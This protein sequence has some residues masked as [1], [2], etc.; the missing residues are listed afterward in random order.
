MALPDPREHPD[1]LARETRTLL[2]RY[3]LVPRRSL[4]QS[5]LTSPAVRDL[6]LR[7][8]ELTPDDV[9]VEIGP[10]TGAL[11]EGLV[12]RVAHVVAIE[13]DRGLY[14]LLMERLGHRHGV[15]VFCADALTFD[16]T[17]LL[18]AMLRAAQR[19]KL[20]S[21]LPYSVATPIILRLLSL[22]RWFSFLLV[23]LQ[24]EV[25][26]RLVAA[27]GHEAYSALTVRCR[28]HADVT[29]VAQVPRA[30]FYPRPAVDSTIVR[31]DLLPQPRVAVHSPDLLFRVVRAAFGQRRKTLR[32]AL[33]HAGIL[34]E[35]GALERAVRAAKIDPNRRGETLDLDDFARLA[36]HL[37]AAGHRASPPTPAHRTRSQRQP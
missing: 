12:V 6:I 13:R 33:A 35:A 16:Y 32:N 25:A 26:Q 4:G 14:R 27:P 3:D 31:L 9:V 28:Y 22:E 2:R 29:V 18:T 36:D 20:I 8:A 7:S 34:P 30:A 19:A 1:S 17:G 24:R 37:Y 23:M 5:F 21:N 15:A 11:T 10:G